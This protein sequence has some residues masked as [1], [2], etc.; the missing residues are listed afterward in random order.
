MIN[1]VY[2]EDDRL[3]DVVPDHSNRPLMASSW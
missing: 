1:L 3:D 2:F